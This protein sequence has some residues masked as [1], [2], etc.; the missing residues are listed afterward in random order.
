[1]QHRKRGRKPTITQEAIEVAKLYVALGFSYTEAA[2]AGGFSRKSLDRLLGRVG[3]TK[4]YE[5][6]N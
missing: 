5:T 3:E 6:H 2:A 4:H 1:M